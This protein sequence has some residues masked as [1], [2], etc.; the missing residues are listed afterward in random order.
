MQRRNVY[1]KNLPFSYKANGANKI[2][3]TGF[4]SS[5]WGPSS[6][7]PKQQLVSSACDLKRPT[8]SNESKIFTTLL[9]SQMCIEEVVLK[10]NKA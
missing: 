9:I 6:K 3:Y 7:T 10:A 8:S 2:Y 5:R 1:F 4:E